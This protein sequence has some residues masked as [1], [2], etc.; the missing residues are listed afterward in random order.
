MTR[1]DG[2]LLSLWLLLVGLIG[3]LSYVNSNHFT[4]TDSTYYL[5]F[6]GWLVG[7]DGDQYG[8]V[9]AGWESTFPVGY[10][11]LIGLMARVTGTSLLVASKLLNLLL[12][13]IFLLI[14]RHR[15]G[16]RRTL[17][18]SSVMLLGGFVRILTYT[19][20]EWPFLL[21]L[22]EWLWFVAQ[23]PELNMLVLKQV[24]YVTKL[25]LLTIG[26]FLLRYVGGYVVLVYALLA[27][28][29]Y[30]RD[31]WTMTR[32]R[33]RNDL[34]YTVSSVL[35]M[36]GYFILNSLL[37][38][39]PFGGDR[40]V[41]ITESPTKIASLVAVAVVNEALIL[42]DFIPGESIWLVVV[43][44]VV[45]IALIRWIWPGIRGQ[46]HTLPNW[47]PADREWLRVLLF[48]GATY[49]VLLVTLRFFSPFS[50]PNARL[51][52]PVT[53]PLFVFLAVWISQWTNVVAR[54]QLGFW[55]TVLLLGSW[56][57]L[58]P[59]VDIWE[60]LHNF[61]SKLT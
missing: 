49:L 47:L 37:T 40:F 58:L 42:R 7:L 55:W 26:L 36:L 41:E 8:H 31:S 13:A 12:I 3:G 28:H 19:W 52:A 29:T 16:A 23:P 15:I 11:L 44:L 60:K 17:W 38:Q 56:L 50:G 54:R 10:P 61:L 21:L 24:R 34:I 43:G 5:S 51:M 18:V 27:I 45:Q 35:F 9:S 2:W 25:L 57:Q 14:W 32:L 33:R 4:S 22:V 30:R 59:Q 6:A 20:S 46:R 53:F 1:D 48:A 39:S